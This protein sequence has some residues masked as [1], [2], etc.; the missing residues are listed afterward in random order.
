MFGN[1][2]KIGNFGTCLG[3]IHTCYIRGNYFVSMF[4][5]SFDT[6]CNKPPRMIRT[7]R[8]NSFFHRPFIRF[9]HRFHPFTVGLGDRV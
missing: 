5:C 8:N 6:T 9:R 2:D 3:T 7:Y 4:V 1:F